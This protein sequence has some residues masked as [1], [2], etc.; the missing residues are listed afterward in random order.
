MCA[1]M[2]ALF[3]CGMTPEAPSRSATTSLQTRSAAS[4][5]GVRIVYDVR[6]AA[7]SLW[8]SCTAGHVIDSFGETRSMYSPRSIE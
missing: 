3:G 4:S 5:D 7:T 8:S 1:L 6:G 2:V